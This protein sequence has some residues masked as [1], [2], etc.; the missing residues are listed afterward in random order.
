MSE[1]WNIDQYGNAALHLDAD[2]L[3]SVIGTADHVELTIRTERV[4]AAVARTYGNVRPGEALLY[5]DPYGSVSIAVNTGDAAAMFR[6]D[7]GREVRIE[8]A[9]VSPSV[10][11][12]AVA[13]SPRSR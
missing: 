11:E 1:V 9:S 2:T 13:M 4:Y 12:A 10:T 3:E 6:L 5:I 8:P 7:A